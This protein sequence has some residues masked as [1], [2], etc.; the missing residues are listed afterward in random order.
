MI[1]LNFR[2]SKNTIAKMLLR[3][4]RLGHPGAEPGTEAGVHTAQ[5]CM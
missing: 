3:H 5:G 2:L 4:L 1:S